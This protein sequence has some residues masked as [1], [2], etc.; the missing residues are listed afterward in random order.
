[1]VFRTDLFLVLTL[2]QLCPFNLINLASWTI[3]YR[4]SGQANDFIH[5]ICVL[6][7]KF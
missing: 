1:M 2:L 7:H 5:H 6:S 4:T 3:L